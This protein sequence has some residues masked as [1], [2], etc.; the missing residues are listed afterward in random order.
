[1]TNAVKFTPS[2]G[3]VAVRAA[4]SGQN[5]MV[6]KVIDTGI[7]IPAELRARVFEPF[8]QVGGHGKSEGVGLG[9]SIVRRLVELHGGTVAVADA[10]PPGT[11]I[12]IVLPRS[13]VLGDGEPAPADNGA[14]AQLPL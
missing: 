2:A 14:Q 7:G 6:I 11:C 10:P 8:F 4:L 13:R 5:D 1:V 3:R 12:E 9:L